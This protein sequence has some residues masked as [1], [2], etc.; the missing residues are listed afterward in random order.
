MN[1]LVVR[2]KKCTKLRET[3]AL[4]HKMLT[5]HRRSQGGLGGPD[6]PF[7]TNETKPRHKL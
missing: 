3:F 6:L 4:I 5:E 2:L 7:F 1:N